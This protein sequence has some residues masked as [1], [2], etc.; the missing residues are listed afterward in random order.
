MKRIA[1]IGLA[2]MASVL[3]SS[4]AIARVKTANVVID[5]NGVVREY[6]GVPLDLTIKKLAKLRFK[7]NLSQEPGDEASVDTVAVI[8]ARTGIRVKAT[9]SDCGHL[10]R[11]ET[12]TR[13]ALGLQSLGVGSTLGELKRAFPSRRP[14]WGA[15]PHGQYY[16]TFGTDTR[17]TYHFSPFDLPKEAWSRDPKQYELPSSI[18]VT[19]ITI[20]PIDP[21]GGC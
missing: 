11:F 21:F 9:F 20:E 7:Y 18:K 1:L 13:G 4:Q 17:L 6:Y 16:A 14:Y 15:T 5:G 3:S 10:W 8:V 19:K 12:K 2:I